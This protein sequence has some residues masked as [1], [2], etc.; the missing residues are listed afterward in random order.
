MTADN[1]LVF[2][3]ETEAILAS[4]LVSAEIDHQA[5]AD[6]LL[7]G[8]VP[9]PKSIYKEIKKLPPGS[10][11]TAAPQRDVAIARYWRPVFAPSPAFTFDEASAQLLDRLDAAVQSQMVSDVPVG[12]FLSGGVDSASIVASM[13]QTAETIRTTTIG[14]ADE[15]FDERPLARQ[16][17]ERYQT[18][19]NE[20]QAAM[21]ATALIDRIAE[22]YG[23]PF[24]DT[25]A[26]PTYLV[27]RET[28]KDVKVALSGDGGD[29]IF[30]GYRRYPF[31]LSEERLRSL[32]PA[33]LRQPIFGAAGALYPKLDFAPRPLRLKTTLQSLGNDTPDAYARAVA[34]NLPDRT[35]AMMSDGL[36]D[37]LRGYDPRSV[38]RTAFEK[39]QSD[40]P[41]SIAQH[42]DL[43]TWLP[44][45]MLVK[46]DRA[47]MAHGLEVRPPL[48]DH[49]LV[50]WAGLLP[51]NFKLQGA[52]GK[53][54]LKAAV[55]ARIPSDIIS[56]KK[57]G[58]GLPVASWLRS[59]NGPLDRLRD[60][61]HWRE[62]GYFDTAIISEMI[63]KHDA[64]SADYS[65]ELWT[66][67]MMDAFL[68]KEKKRAPFAPPANS[69][70]RASITA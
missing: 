6:Y 55:E 34:A 40:D 61:D 27:C 14:F 4:G 65:Q 46:V 24:A 20:H 39:A 67:I 54:I 42:I 57:R 58:F 66:V 25:S 60:S 43:R 44:G 7:Y 8:Y 2:A 41:L 26:L 49:Q 3:S 1:F 30:A 22:V 47:S 52:I 18:Q 29:E 59:E 15:A 68:A 69:M 9:D 21:D 51:S 48:L 33:V 31:H 28:R 50:E 32:I 17:A 10:M 56:G 53:R 13:A 5:L 62:S 35:A 11:L 19:H 37:D 16:V 64:S 63:K 23:E 36:K 38:V 12:A 45:R 70:Q